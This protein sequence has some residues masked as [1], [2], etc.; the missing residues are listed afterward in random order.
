LFENF[1]NI[2]YWKIVKI[3]TNKKIE[4]CHLFHTISI[5]MRNLCTKSN[6]SIYQYGTSWCSARLFGSPRQRSRVQD[7]L[8]TINIHEGSHWFLRTLHVH[9]V[10]NFEAAKSAILE[11]YR[12]FVFRLVTRWCVFTLDQFH[13]PWC[14]FNPDKLCPLPVTPKGMNQPWISPYSELFRP[15]YE[16][17]QDWFIPFGVTGWCVFHPL[18]TDLCKALQWRLPSFLTLFCSIYY[19]Y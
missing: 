18:I 13:P 5:A 14:S 9:N 7:R 6:V 2:L 1:P 10:Q 12:F 3:I 4:F 15:E 11:I 8:S 19:I 17:I 16:L